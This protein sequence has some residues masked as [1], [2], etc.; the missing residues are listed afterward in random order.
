[1]KL[2][3]LDAKPL[4]RARCLHSYLLTARNMISLCLLLAPASA[5][6]ARAPSMPHRCTPAASRS[7]HLVASSRREVLSFGAAA[8]AFL[9]AAPPRAAFA[10]Q[11]PNDL[12]RFKRALEGVNYLLNNW[13]KETTEC[14]TS[15]NGV[16]KDTPDKVRFYFG[17]RTTDHPLFGL[18]KLYAKAQDKLPDD[19]D[20]EA[21]IQ[22]TEDLA[23]QIAKI[24]EL[25][26]TCVCCA[27][28]VPLLRPPTLRRRV[29]FGPTRLRK[30]HA[31]AGRLLASTTRVA[32]RSLSAST[33]S[34]P[35]NRWKNPKP[36][37]K[38]S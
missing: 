38:P 31:R 15:G 4:A 6:V 2:E 29:R 34:S 19:V 25:A 28:P 16:C 3:A 32:A 17:L 36:R 23:S 37:W 11:D 13:D 12:S 7:C 10:S 33:S 14:E 5:L 9:A 35:K 27:P 26:Y 24:N 20:F 1:M 30:L 18:D 21:W 22:A 8:A